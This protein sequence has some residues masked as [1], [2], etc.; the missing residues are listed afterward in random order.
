MCMCALMRAEM[1]YLE[2]T[3]VFSSATC[4]HIIAG[5]NQEFFFQ[6]CSSRVD[7]EERKGA[8]GA[9][10]IGLKTNGSKLYRSNFR[11]VFIVKNKR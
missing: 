3:C 4:P 6:I 2:P 9:G 7:Y 11:A 8:G 1:A 10:K 5:I